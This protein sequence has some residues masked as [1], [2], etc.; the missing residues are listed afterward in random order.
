L[1][2]PSLEHYIRKTEGSRLALDE[3]SAQAREWYAREWAST[4]RRVWHE[5]SEMIVPQIDVT[6]EL[7][8]N[9][10]IP[11]LFLAASRTVKLPLEEA[12]FWARHAP[13]GRLEIIDSASQGLAFAKADDCA[14]RALSFLLEQRQ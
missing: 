1:A 2:A 4:A 3:V 14:R 8:Q 10:Q 6:V 9:L 7:L 5:W 12:R 13:K 11:L